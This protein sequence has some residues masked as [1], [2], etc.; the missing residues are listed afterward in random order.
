[1]TWCKDI[2]RDEAVRAAE[3]GRAAPLPTLEEAIDRMIPKS[4]SGSSA[5]EQENKGD[6]MATKSEIQ[7]ADY[8]AEAI[9]RPFTEAAER[10][11][12]VSETGEGQS[13]LRTERVTLE[14]TRR[15]AGKPLRPLERC[16]WNGMLYGI[17]I[18]PEPGESVRVVEE[19]H[20]D[21]LAQVAMQR[22]ALIRE[23]AEESSALR[24]MWRL[25][26]EACYER[27]A[28]RDAAIRERDKLR[29]EITSVLDRAEQVR[30]EHDALCARVAE[31][32]ARNVT[33]GEGS[34]AAP[35]ASG[36]EQQG[37]SDG[38]SGAPACESGQGSRLEAASGG[39]EGEPVAWGVI[40]HRETAVLCCPFAVKQA[41]DHFVAL[42]SVNE[43]MSVVPLYA[44]PPQPRGW[45]TEEERLALAAARTIIDGGG[46]TNI[47]VTID[48]L[49]ARSS[50]PEVVLPPFKGEVTGGPWAVAGY[51]SAIEVC[52]EALAAAGVA[53][54]E[55]GRE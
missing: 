19:T 50:P 44:A 24:E 4:V 14:V 25:S 35:A 31:L 54:K 15:S 30:S 8:R 39:G 53:V 9:A 51:N 34:C 21:D 48:A 23:H 43:T 40:L 17:V 1:M 5:V 13:G 22:D 49:L 28:E 12:P 10:S 18:G 27:A 29:S 16:N 2:A 47:G 33:A 6:D 42:N 3:D 7:A 36:P 20:F 11:V 46:R 41:A 32:E 38:T 52:R 55:V 45:L 37:V 26:R